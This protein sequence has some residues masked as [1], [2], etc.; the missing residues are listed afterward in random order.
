MKIKMKVLHL[1]RMVAMNSIDELRIDKLLEKLN[2]NGANLSSL[3]T[4]IYARKSTKDTSGVSIST[5]INSCKKYID[6]TTKLHLVEE[7]FE[8]NVSGYRMDNRKQIKA[9]IEEVKNRKNP[10]G[11]C[12]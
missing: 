4:A 8:E 12:V 11:S 10:S 2:A 3:P 7:Y 1:E 9:L 5:Q 6:G